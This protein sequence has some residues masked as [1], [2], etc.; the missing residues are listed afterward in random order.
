MKNL[1]YNVNSTIRLTVR[2]TL[3]YDSDNNNKFSISYID[4]ND[5]EVIEEADKFLKDFLDT[6]MTLIVEMRNSA[7]TTDEF[8]S[9]ISNE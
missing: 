9:S 2:G 7:D 4:D 6:N 1:T 3:K 5:E 8:V